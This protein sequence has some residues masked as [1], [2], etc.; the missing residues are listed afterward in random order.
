MIETDIDA[1]APIMLEVFNNEIWKNIW[2]FPRA[3]AYLLDFY[4]NRK[5]V[6]YTA[7]DDNKIVGGIF[8]IEK[9]WWSSDEVSIEEF[10]VSPNY[11]GKK[12]GTKLLDEVI[13]YVKEHNFGGICLLTNK[14]SK[15]YE[16]YLKNG[17]VLNDEIVCMYKVIN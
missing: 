9:V 12:I 11:Q 1:L 10:F 2:T 6:G 4:K 8:G 15:A 3:K 16:Y 7:I 17:F 5:F 14:N 13:K